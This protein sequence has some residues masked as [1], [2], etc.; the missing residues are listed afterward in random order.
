[1]SE[2]RNYIAQRIVEIEGAKV[3]SPEDG[4]AHILNISMCGLRAEVV[5]HAL[6]Q[7]DIYIGTGSAC[8]SKKT[9]GSRI[10][11]ALGLDKQTGEGAIRLSFNEKSSIAEADAFLVQVRNI[12]A[13]FA[14]FRRR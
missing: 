4:A 8:S 10:H 1:M 12:H 7:H 6:E 9:K 2:V 14:G 3:I 13:K 5:V 11:E